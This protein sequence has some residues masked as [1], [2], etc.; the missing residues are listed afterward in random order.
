MW[1]GRDIPSP[2]ILPFFYIILYWPC[3]FSNSL[4][5]VVCRDQC[6]PTLQNKKHEIYPRNKFVYQTV[7]SQ[8]RF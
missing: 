5:R 7:L 3:P 1:M 4:R 2:P 8:R 6:T